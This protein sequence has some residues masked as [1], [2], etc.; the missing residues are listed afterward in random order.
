MLKVK[1]FLSLIILTMFAAFFTT[2]CSNVGDGSTGLGGGHL[3]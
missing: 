3:R 1:P 2:A